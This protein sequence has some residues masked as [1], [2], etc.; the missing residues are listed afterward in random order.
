MYLLLTANPFDTVSKPIISLL[1]M[2]LT[3]RKSVV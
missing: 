1:E 2:A 3:D